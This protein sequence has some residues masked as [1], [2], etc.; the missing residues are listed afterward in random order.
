LVNGRLELGVRAEVLAQTDVLASVKGTSNLILFETDR[1]GTLG[2][3]SLFPGVEQTAYGVLVD[4]TDVL[5]RRK[6][7]LWRMV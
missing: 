7:R 3:V 1:M 4:L 2:T 5:A 6:T